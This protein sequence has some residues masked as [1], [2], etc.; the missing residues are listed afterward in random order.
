MGKYLTEDEYTDLTGSETDFGT[1]A[2][3]AAA[4]ELVDGYLRRQLV[5]ERRTETA[6][7]EGLSMLL[8]AYP[9]TEIESVTDGDGSPLAYRANMDSGILRL[10]ALPAGGCVTVIYTGGLEDIPSAVKYAVALLTQA[11]GV[12]A[13]NGGRSIT[14]ERLD[15]YSVTYSENDNSGPLPSLSR[16]AAALLAPFRGRIT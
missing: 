4:E 7:A 14:S 8:K 5:L 13:E 15:G 11:I 12:S 2:R 3:I 9:V 6:E 10:N 16:A 1:E